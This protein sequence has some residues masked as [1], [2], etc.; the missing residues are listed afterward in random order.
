M[1]LTEV[2][3]LT[4]RAPRRDEVGRDRARDGDRAREDVAGAEVEAVGHLQETSRQ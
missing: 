3:F 4:T 1:E 2:G